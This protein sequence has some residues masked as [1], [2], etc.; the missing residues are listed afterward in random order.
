M[1]PINSITKN[2]HLLP[3]VHYDPFTPSQSYACFHQ[4]PRYHCEPLIFNPL[5][6]YS[7][8]HISVP[9]NPISNIRILITADSINVATIPLP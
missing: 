6:L 7:P 5:F 4:K 1:K 3:E 9:F 8:I 2:A